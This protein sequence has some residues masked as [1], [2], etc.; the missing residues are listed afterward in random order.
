MCGVCGNMN[1]NAN[2]DFV[3]SDGV[4]VTTNSNKYSLIGNSWRVEDNEDKKY[5]NY[6]SFRYVI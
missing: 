1:D 4:D 5:L 6:V 2:D 3:T